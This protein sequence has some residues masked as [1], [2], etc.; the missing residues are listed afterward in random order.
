MNRRKNFGHRRVLFAGSRSLH[1]E[2]LYR[3]TADYAASLGVPLLHS[4]AAGGVTSLRPVS[5]MG[6]SPPCGGGFPDWLLFLLNAGLCRA[7]RVMVYLGAHH[8]RRERLAG[9]LFS[10]PSGAVCDRDSPEAVG[11]LL[12][13]SPST[14]RAARSSRRLNRKERT[15]LSGYLRG[16]PAH[17]QARACGLSV[18]SV[19]RLRQSGLS[20]LGLQS[21]A[22]LAGAA[23]F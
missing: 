18:K 10:C 21:L 20:R 17:A 14:L 8:C 11:R 7:E 2:G 5:L 6:C 4:E 13:S 19:Y 15:V 12:R 22:G 9:M 3:L 16:M 23:A 1:S